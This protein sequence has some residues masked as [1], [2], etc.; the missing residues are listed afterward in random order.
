METHSNPFRRT[1]V[2]QALFWVSMLVSRLGGEGSSTCVKDAFFM[3]TISKILGSRA[4]GYL[5][6]VPIMDLLL[7]LRK[8][9]V[10]SMLHQKLMSYR[11]RDSLSEFRNIFGVQGGL[12][13]PGIFGEVPCGTSLSRSRPF[14]TEDP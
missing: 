6:Q 4:L 11:M 14:E 3:P 2:F 1:V 5:A 13:V 9:F 8:P 10:V 7:N 12:A